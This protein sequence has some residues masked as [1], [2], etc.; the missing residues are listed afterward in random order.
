FAP[1]AQYPAM[2]ANPTQQ[3][4]VAAAVEL[5]DVVVDF[6][7]KSDAH[8][9]AW[10]AS[11]LTPLARFAFRGPSPLF[12][13]DANVRS[14]GKSLLADVIG[15]IVAGR[16]MARTPQ[17]PDEGEEIKRSTAIAV[18]GTRLVLIDN[19]NRPLG[20]GALDAVLTGT[21]WSNRI[22]GKTEN[23]HVPLL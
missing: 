20:S 3:Q 6:P 9:A 14:A 8:R 21:V 13:I 2:P 16:E 18:D 22:L 12:V 7:F 15:E 17:A 19:I 4:A 23:V 10:L 1:N 5:L 11:V